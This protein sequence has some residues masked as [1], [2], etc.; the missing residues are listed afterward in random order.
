M[1]INPLLIEQLPEQ[2]ILR[3]DDHLLRSSAYFQIHPRNFKFTNY[4]HGSW[5][6]K[7]KY[8]IG[9]HLYRYFNKRNFLFSKFEQGIAIDE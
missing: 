7:E 4:D 6:L 2:Q 8:G 9:K 3:E 1:E 5:A